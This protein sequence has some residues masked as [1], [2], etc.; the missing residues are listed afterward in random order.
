MQLSVLIVDDEPLARE[1]LSLLLKQHALACEVRMARNGREAVNM[2][3]QQRPDLILLDIQ[4]PG[5]NGFEV[6]DAIGAEQMPMV[7]FVTAHDQY[8]IRAF[9]VSATDYLLKPVT[10]ERFNQAL[11][12][13]TVRLR[14]VPSE[15][16][17]NRM[18]AMLEAIANPPRHLTRFAIRTGD[19]TLF[20]P[21]EQ[22]DRIE[23]LQNYARLH[24]SSGIHTLHVTMNAIESSLDPA[25]FLRVH[26]SHI[27][28]TH[29]V[30]QFWS[31]SHGQYLIELA[32]GDRVQSG[33]SYVEKVRRALAN[34]F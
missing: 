34:P 32:S 20:V 3:R 33:R 11:E 31:L 9:E 22:V 7:I 21:V 18:L 26:R 16:M 14:A 30:R 8:A 6:V 10:Q 23:A 2:I 17:P 5:M 29:R 4:M 13:A 27:I 25:S 19:R 28:N 15:D 1:G 24:T 12:R